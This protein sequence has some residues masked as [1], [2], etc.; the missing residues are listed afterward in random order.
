MGGHDSL[1]HKGVQALQLADSGIRLE[2]IT[3]TMAY[4]MT[5]AGKI[6]MR[7]GDTQSVSRHAVEGTPSRVAR[8]LRIRVKD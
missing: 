6:E 8:G 3:G 7:A 2:P 4:D 5:E 1:R